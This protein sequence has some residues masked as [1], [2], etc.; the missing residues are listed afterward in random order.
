MKSM[1]LHYSPQLQLCFVLSDVFI[2]KIISIVTVCKH[3]YFIILA[4][5]GALNENP[6]SQVHVFKHL[7]PSSSVWEGYGTLRMGVLLQ[8]VCH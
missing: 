1:K 3:S 6:T 2:T 5:C 7:F 8:K 4:A